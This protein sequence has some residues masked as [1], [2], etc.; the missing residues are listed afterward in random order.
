MDTGREEKERVLE[1]FRRWG[2]LQADLDPVGYLEPEAVPELDLAGEIH[3]QQ[4]L[5]RVL[6]RLSLVVDRHQ[7]R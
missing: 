2:Y 4:T 3:I 6:D 7:D 5:D 1:C